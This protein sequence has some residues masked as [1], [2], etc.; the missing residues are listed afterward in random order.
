MT[1]IG[2]SI[3]RVRYIKM[4]NFSYGH[5]KP[6][7]GFAKQEWRKP[8]TGRGKAVFSLIGKRWA[9]YISHVR[10]CRHAFPESIWAWRRQRGLPRHQGIR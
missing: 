9:R 6:V 8:N 1:R 5:K 7:S 3:I 4:G 2:E 10:L